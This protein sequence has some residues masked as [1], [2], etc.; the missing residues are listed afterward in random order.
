MNNSEEKKRPNANYKLSKENSNPEEITYYYNRERRLERAPQ[1]VRDLYNEESPR[2]RFNF[3]RSLSGAKPRSIMLAT[4]LMASIMIAAISYFNLASDTYDLD[5]NRLT[6]QAII[7]E[8]TIIV[9]LKKS[10]RKDKVSRYVNPYTGAVNIAISPALRTG[11]D[12][13][14]QPEDVFYHRIFFTLEPVE[15]YRFAVPFDP[16][17]LAMVFQTEKKTLSLTIKPE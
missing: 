13:V 17:E 15:F 16:A 11:S 9:A 2:R 3:F 1:A 14:L 12:R 6:V 7:Y 5:G 4:I 8:D 10:T